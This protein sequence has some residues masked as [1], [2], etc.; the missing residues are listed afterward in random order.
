MSLIRSQCVILLAGVLMTCAATAQ[1]ASQSD[2]FTAGHATLNWVPLGDACLTMGDGTGSIPSCASKGLPTDTGSGALL[3][4]PAVNYQTGAILSNFTFPMS[5]GLSV[6]FTTYT[7]GST[8]IGAPA[9]LGADGITFF[10]TD[11]TQNLP[12]DTGATGGAM[13]YTCSTTNLAATN[14]WNGIY[15]GYLGLGMDEYGNYLNSGD[16]SG[17]GVLNTNNTTPPPGAVLAGLGGNTWSTNVNGAITGGSGPQY[18]PNRIGMRGA[19]NVNFR[20]LNAQ[21]PAYYS[22]NDPTKIS[23]VC[24]TGEYVSSGTE[25]GQN[26]K[27]VMNYK[28]IPGA[29][30]ALP[31]DQPLAAPSAKTRTAGFP[32]TYKIS[33]ST[34]GLLNFS[35]SYNG[36]VFQTVL[37]NENISTINGAPPG[38]FRFGFSAG[39]GGQN[40]VHEITCFTAAPLQSSSSVGANTVT[41]RVTGDT[42]IFLAGFSPDNWWGS[43][44]ADPLVIKADGT[45]D[46]GTAA[47]WDAK[48]VLTGANPCGSMTKTDPTT[49]TT[50]TYPITVQDPTTRKLYTSTALGEGTGTKLGDISAAEQ[51]ALDTTPYSNPATSDGKGAARLQWLQGVRSVEQLQTPPGSLRAR[52][53]VLGD[54]IDSSPT[55]VGAPTPGALPDSFADKLHPSAAVPESAAGATTYSA[56]VTAQAGRTNVVYVGSNDGFMHGFRAGSYSSGTFQTATND[57]TE[58][59]GYMPYDV[60]MHQAADL[61]D[62]LYRH[63]YLVDATPVAGDVF[64]NQTWH[65]WLVG[66][67]GSGGSEIFAL[68]V[69]NPDSFAASNVVGDWDNGTLPHL[70]STVGTPIITRM[71]DGKWAIVFGSGL[72]DPCTP[73]AGGTCTS[74]T[75]GVYVGLINP[76][77]GSVTFTFLDT[78]AQPTSV[79]GLPGGIT[80]V[81]QVDLDGDHTADYLYAG[82]TQG[83]VWKFDVTSATETDWKVNPAPVFQAKDSSGNPQPITTAI[84]IL[85]L[86]TGTQ[87]RVMLY[88]GT[89]QQVPSSTNGPIQYATGTQ[90]FYGIWDADMSAWNAESTSTYATLSAQPSITRDT[91]LGQTPTEVSGTPVSGGTTP[92]TGST[93]PS[94]LAGVPRRTLST[95]KAVCWKGD[96]VSSVCSANEQYGWYMDLPDQQSGAGSS[97][98]IIY[99]P[100]FIGGAVVVNTAIP[101]PTSAVQCVN[102]PQD[103][104]TMAFNPATG[105]GF[106]K[107]YFTDAGGGFSSGDETVGGVKLAGVGT[108]TSLV[109]EDKTY[110]VTQTV[111]GAAKLIPTNWPSDASP[112]RVSWR[113]LV[114]P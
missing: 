78:S 74:P 73:P 98:Q 58:L 2:D 88:F 63:A 81:S 53:Y 39:T 94:G 107:G 42:Q 51:A 82:D 99:S 32:V 90:T 21:N 54:I 29:Y 10:L 77:D 100:T 27:S 113:E 103:G 56:F 83:R 25:A 18:Q 109:H 8:S 80:Y 17:D 93:D 22:D 86:Q 50:T 105:G 69:T 71:H 15:Y 45:L 1:V 28:V 35:Y 14:K 108:P 30:T 38:A 3:L 55:F 46:I 19:G 104:W 52:T 101:P 48:C 76:S 7:F 111:S 70:G 36:G 13:G 62:P 9:Y 20:W 26:L 102:K 92:A 85:A 65:T 66:G 75:E 16:N 72:V 114:N 110:L 24:K 47:N 60:L 41:G 106:P 43:L 61:T 91:L 95:T 84:N 59:L 37:A 89:G 33:I 112:A 64:Y 87:E 57:G 31:N 12:T 6:T 68:D 79:D 34:S 40:N 44:V 11:G 23:H 5:Q 97:E 96:P 49:G 4:T 67:V